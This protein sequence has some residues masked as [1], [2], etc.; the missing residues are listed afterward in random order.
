MCKGMNAENQYISG[1]KHSLFC[2][3]AH[4]LLCEA[5]MATAGLQEEDT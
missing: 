4:L 3:H 2:A 5:F 1:E